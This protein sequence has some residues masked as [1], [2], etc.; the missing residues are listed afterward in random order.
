MP[1]LRRLRLE[2]TAKNLIWSTTYAFIKD[3]FNLF[4]FTCSL[5]REGREERMECQSNAEG[6]FERCGDSKDN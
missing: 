1:T 3:V 6:D 5:S 4:D 2:S